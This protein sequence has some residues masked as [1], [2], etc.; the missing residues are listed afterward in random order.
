MLAIN[1]TKVR[2]EWSAVVESVIREKPAFI[3]KTRDYLFLS[4]ID[5]LEKILAAYTF[6][7]KITPEN[8]GSVTLSLD[9]IGLVE[10]APDLPCA[11]SALSRAILEYAEDFYNEFAYWSR[12]NGQLHIPYVLKALILNDINKIGE[13]IKCRHGKN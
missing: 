1:A 2:N 13:L 11:V 5:V 10:N 6:H 12:G 9:E 8:D 3:K 4:D 7:A